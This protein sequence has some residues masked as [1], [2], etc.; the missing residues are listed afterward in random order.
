VTSDPKS[1]NPET[2][3]PVQEPEQANSRDAIGGQVSEPNTSDEPA[4]ELPI[5]DQLRAEA[6]RLKDQLLRLAADFDNFRKRSRREISDAERMAR[7]ELL[8]EL[9]PVFD[10][11][12]RASQHAGAATDVQSLVDGVSMVTRQFVDTLGRLGVERVQAVGA[13]FDPAVHEAVQQVETA[14]QPP[15]VVCAEILAGYRFGE[16]LLRPAMVV[17]AKAPISA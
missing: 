3:P 14:D 9:L 2:E 6:T 1:T 5:E 16:R 10:N 7:E 12:D 8:R 17:V 4:P 13:A 15:G 11:L